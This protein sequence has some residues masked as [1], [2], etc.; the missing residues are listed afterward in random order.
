MVAVPDL[1]KTDIFIVKINGVDVSKYLTSYTIN[2]YD[3]TTADTGMNDAGDTQIEYV[4]K[5]KLKAQFKWSDINS[6]YYHK[7]EKTIENGTITAEIVIGDNKESITYD[8][9][10][11]DRTI[12]MKR[13]VNNKPEWDYTFSIIGL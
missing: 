6:T 1:E 8:A 7:I 4:K 13:D 10:R 5:D 12:T 9:Y 2:K 3:I 11:G